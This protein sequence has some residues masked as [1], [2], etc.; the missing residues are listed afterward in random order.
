M[1]FA[2]QTVDLIRVGIGELHGEVLVNATGPKVAKTILH[3]V[4]ELL[5]RQ[6]LRAAAAIAA[7]IPASGGYT[8]R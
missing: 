1:N 6:F 5:H 7:V 2:Q 3:A 8:A 4:N